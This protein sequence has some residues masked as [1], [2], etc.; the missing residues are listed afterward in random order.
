MPPVTARKIGDWSSSAVTKYFQ[1]YTFLHAYGNEWGHMYQGWRWTLARS[2]EGFDFLCL[3]L[4][5]LKKCGIFVVN[6]TFTTMELSNANKAIL[7][8]IEK[9]YRIND[10][11][12]VWRKGKSI[13]LHMGGN[14]YKRFVIK[15]K[16]SRSTYTIEAHRFQAFRKF[17]DK[18]FG[19]G[20][21]V[22]HLN[23]NHCDNRYE[24]IGIG[25]QSQNM[26][27]VPKH[28]RKERS[29]RAGLKLRKF[30]DAE[31]DQI[32]NDRK[33]GMKY[34]ELVDKYGASISFYKYMF[35]KSSYASEPR[36]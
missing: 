8:A 23:D 32:K 20:L 36:R 12:N 25:T 27:D 28:I 10:Y 1:E 6:K 3:H 15:R 16:H 11:G 33:N 2:V 13:T 21:G 4:F 30:S 14:G 31:V 34:K 9:G 19:R 18:I 26:M 17:G 22:R 29:K 35:N 7:L 5:V 24:N